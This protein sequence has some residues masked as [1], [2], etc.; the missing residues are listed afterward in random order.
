MDSSELTISSEDS[1]IDSSNFHGEGLAQIQGNSGGRS[2]GKGLAQISKRGNRGGRGNN[3]GSVTAGNT[4]N[5]GGHGLAQTEGW[6]GFGDDS[7]G[8]NSITVASDSVAE[9]TEHKG[10]GLAQIGS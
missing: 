3:S 10:H 1:S 4:T 6:F 9:A 8:E 2:K 7:D 5:S